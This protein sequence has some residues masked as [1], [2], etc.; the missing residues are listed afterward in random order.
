[1]SHPFDRGAVNG[2]PLF[3]HQLHGAEWLLMHLRG[4]LYGD[5]GVGKTATAAKAMQV[6]QPRTAAVFTPLSTVLHWQRELW[7]W[8][9]LP[10]R[11]VRDVADVTSGGVMIL[12]PDKLYKPEILQALRTQKFDVLVLDEC[13]MFKN[14]E[15]KR[16]R[17]VYGRGNG[18]VHNAVW[19]W[20][21]SGTPYPQGPIDFYVPLRV[22]FPGVVDGMSRDQF[23]ERSMCSTPTACAFS[24]PAT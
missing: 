23:I 2:Q 10:S 4:L 16:T 7:Q 17:F 1:M 22:L 21:L 9:G 18:L 13:Q 20:L 6:L 14:P 24:A 5:P 8:G 15:A 3:G 19:T 12:N 11:V